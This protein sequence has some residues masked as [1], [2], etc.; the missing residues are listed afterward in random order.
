MRVLEER[1]WV[2]RTSPVSMSGIQN[3]EKKILAD[4]AGAC[5]WLESQTKSIQLT[6][7][8]MEIGGAR[9]LLAAILEETPALQESMI[10]ADFQ[11]PSEEESR[12]SRSEKGARTPRK[13]ARRGKAR[14]GNG[15]GFEGTEG[16]AE[17][18]VCSMPYYSVPQW[19]MSLTPEKGKGG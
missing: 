11:R 14:Q 10:S 1:K 17:V 6:A 19:C 8:R 5:Q 3:P 9:R 15:M 16:S 13:G 12:C 2:D 18:I 7:V 4:M